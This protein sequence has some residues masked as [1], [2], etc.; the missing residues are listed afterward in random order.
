VRGNTADLGI[1]DN[2]RVQFRRKAPDPGR[3]KGS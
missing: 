2:I 1:T 3:R